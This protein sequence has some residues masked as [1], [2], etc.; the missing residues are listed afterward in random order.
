MARALT[1]AA[2]KD[3][4][5]SA[6]AAGLVYTANA[7]PGITRVKRGK[8]FAYLDAQRRAVRDK[9][10]LAR[11][12]SLVIPP[13]WADVWICTN[14]RGHL[15]AT[16]RDARGRKQYR[17]HPKWREVRDDTKYG[18]MIA[19]GQALPVIRRRTEADLR[20]DGL[21]REKV[22]AAVVRLLEKTFIRVGNDE[23]AR[24]NKSFGLT[25]MRDGHVKVSGSTV[26]FIFRGKSGVEHALALDDRRLAK[27]V[28][29]CRDLPG[30][31]LFQYKD[32]TGAVVDIGSGDVNAYLK[33]IT[34]EDFTS[35]D[36]RTWAGTV[37]AAQLL[38]A[39]ERVDSQARAKKNVVAAI[40]HV[41][42]QLGNTRAVCRKCYVHPAVI[43][44]YLDGTMMKTVAQRARAVQAVGKLTAAE[45]AVLSLLQ[46]RSASRSKLSARSA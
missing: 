3:P 28:K 20:R 12:R 5:V 42:K 19:F 35:K 36:F 1:L 13:A 17:Y 39:Y 11:I 30:Q 21:P 27:I 45:T 43:D 26:R 6:R 34:G 2:A 37:L 41:A 44:A 24:D 31:E 29:Q 15:Q 4:L 7:Q 18:R 22:L 46:R 8:A 14:P 16:G 33:E 32:D 40:E 23:Y 25:T 10:T 9:E 38:R